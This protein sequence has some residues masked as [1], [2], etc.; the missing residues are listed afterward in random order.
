[1]RLPGAT[2]LIWLTFA[3]LLLGWVVYQQ[4]Q[5]PCRRTLPYAIGQF[6]SQFGETEAE[7][8]SSLEAA[9][10]L[11]EEP[12]GFDLFT[13][14]PEASLKVNLIFDERQ[15]T[16]NSQNQL[17]DEIVSG[18]ADFDT[19]KTQYET[20]RAEYE[21]RSAVLSAKIEQY[22]SQ[23]GAPSDVYQELEAERRSLNQLASNLNA[24]A[25]DLQLQAG[26]LNAKI[27][28]FN[29]HVGH[30]FDQA[31]YTG[32]AINLYEFES[33]EDQVVALA[34][35]FGHALGLEHVA[36][37]KAIMY[38]LL[39]EQNMTNPRLAQADVD[40]LQELCSRRPTLRSMIV[41]GQQ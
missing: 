21:R 25:E 1:M 17:E 27:D 11:W 31:T 32:E 5:T 15:A 35:E 4:Y 26:Q 30:I 23:G 18:S 37:P 28:S 22:N 34:H 7:F 14:D 19:K 24:V 36:D 33:R 40:A 9:A 13:Y 3:G 38:Y 16:V 10:A 8:K 12:T 41:G 2:T 6:D 39:Q 29:I 20:K